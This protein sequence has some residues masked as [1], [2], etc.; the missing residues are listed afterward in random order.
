MHISRLK[1]L[2][3]IDCT[4]IAIIAPKDHEEAYINHHG[5][6]SLNVQ[7]MSIEMDL[8]NVFNVLITNYI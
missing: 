5:Y 3:E 4:H 7:M 1:E 8:Y 2:L 6:H